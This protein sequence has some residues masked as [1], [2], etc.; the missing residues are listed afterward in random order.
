M[1]DKS[2]RSFFN[3]FFVKNAIKCVSEAHKAYEDTKND[4]DYFNSFESAYPLIS[5]SYSFL[6]DE[7]IRLGI[8]TEG[9]TK[10]EIV[11]EIYER[12]KNVP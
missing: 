4:L 5:E 3:E 12:N 11:R 7:V 1:I 6:E 2:R 10:L 8:D 9:M